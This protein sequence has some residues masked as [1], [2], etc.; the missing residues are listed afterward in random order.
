MSQMLSEHVMI[1]YGVHKIS[2]MI[3]VLTEFIV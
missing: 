1:H 3:P 2:K